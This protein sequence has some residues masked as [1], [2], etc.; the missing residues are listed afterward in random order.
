VSVAW[1]RE[2]PSTRENRQAA[3]RKLHAFRQW[4]GTCTFGQP[5]RCPGCREKQGLRLLEFRNDFHPTDTYKIPSILAVCPESFDRYME[6]KETGTVFGISALVKQVPWICATPT[7]PHR[8]RNPRPAGGTYAHTDTFGPDLSGMGFGSS[9]PI[10]V[11][12]S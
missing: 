1:L 7:A 3:Q 5:L 10:P 12:G 2:F 8:P 11:A 6:L 4:W 9:R